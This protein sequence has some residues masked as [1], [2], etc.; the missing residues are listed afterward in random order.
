MFDENLIMIY[1]CHL[2][3]IQ[4]YVYINFFSLKNVENN[5]SFWRSYLV[6]R[7]LFLACV[8][9]MLTPTDSSV[10]TVSSSSFPQTDLPDLFTS[11]GVISTT[12]GITTEFIVTF[13]TATQPKVTTV[14]TTVTNAQSVEFTLLDETNTPVQTQVCWR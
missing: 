2:I 14:T 10:M 13:T 8:D 12:S 9:V 7:A 5:N 11:V 6:T 4:H 1:H 3:L